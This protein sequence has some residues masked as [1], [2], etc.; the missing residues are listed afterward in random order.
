MLSFLVKYMVQ[1]KNSFNERCYALLRKIPRGKVTTYKALALA[2]NT[3]AHRA[4]NFP[5]KLFIQDS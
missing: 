1:E 2:L 3:K 4:F 5:N